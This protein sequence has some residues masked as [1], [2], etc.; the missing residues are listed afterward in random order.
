[1]FGVVVAATAATGCSEPTTR[2][3]AV[4]VRVVYVSRLPGGCPDQANPCYPMCAHHNAPAGLQAIVPLWGDG[5]TLRLSPT[6]AGRYEGVLGAVPVDTRLRLYGRDLGACCID[7]CSY[8]PVLDE[9]SLNGTRL[10]H[11]VHDGLPAGIP[12]ALEFTVT[13]DGSVRN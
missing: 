11:V 9:I 13:A 10:T 1:L 5:A 4:D 12:S 7:A 2:V 3:I 8:P 6:A